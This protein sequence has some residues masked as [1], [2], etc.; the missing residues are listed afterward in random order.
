[1][2]EH[3]I[4]FS[5]EMVKAILDGRKTQTRR[6]IKPQPEM[7]FEG[8]C[9]F[10]SNMI[11]VSDEDMQSHLFHD[12]YGEKGTPYGA[13]Y[14]DGTADRL[15]VRETFGVYDS[16]VCCEN[17]FPNFKEKSGIYRPIVHFAGTENYAWGMYGPPRKRPGIHMPRR[18]CRIELEI[19]DV[20]VERVQDISHEDVIAEGGP[21][22]YSGSSDEDFFTLWDTINAKRGFSA[23]SNPFVWVIEFRKVN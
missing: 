6:V 12:V 20:R 19:V 18:A 7:R 14:G 5:S 11:F 8:S 22:G 16:I 2:N 3:P 10:Y 4:L 1:M 15:W 23:Q 17:D 13:V 9:W 21:F